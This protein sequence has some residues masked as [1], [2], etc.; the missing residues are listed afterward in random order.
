MAQRYAELVTVALP[1]PAQKEMEQ[2]MAT[3]SYLY[4]GEYAR[5]LKA[6]GR[7]EGEARLLLLVADSR[8]LHLSEQD[9]RRIL[10]CRDTDTLER[11]ARRTA[12]AT[13]AEEIFS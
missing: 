6:E 9:R 4:Q 10:D 8:G 11:W 1:E 13:T 3:Q 12:T 2:L 5:S 7:A